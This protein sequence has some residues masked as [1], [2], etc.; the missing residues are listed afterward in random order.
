MPT[1]LQNLLKAVVAV[2]AELRETESHAKL[3]G[4]AF[5]KQACKN[6]NIDTKRLDALEK[7]LAADH[8]TA[9]TESFLRKA[10][11]WLS[12][13]TC[14]NPPPPDRFAKMLRVLGN[15]G[16]PVEL[17]RLGVTSGEAIALASRRSVAKFPDRYADGPGDL[18]E[19]RAHI[20]RLHDKR[21]ALLAQ[22]EIAVAGPDIECDDKGAK[23]RGTDVPLV[24]GWPLRLLD[25]GAATQSRTRNKIPSK[26]K[27]A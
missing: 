8:E 3:N 13:P 14:P 16:L 19:H 18:E 6:G 15:D 27:A 25:F 17:A 10:I 4:K 7:A 20:Q 2:D 9:S 24:A 26:Q 5:L 21:M 23:V 1:K 11:I 22:M 12:E